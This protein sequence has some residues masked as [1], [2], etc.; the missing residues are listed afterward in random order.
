[1]NL[2]K[3]IGT[4]LAHTNTRLSALV[5]GAVSVI[6]CS[7]G[8]GALAARSSNMI[9]R[10][11]DIGFLAKAMTNILIVNAQ[12]VNGAAMSINPAALEAGLFI[13]VASLG[14][15]V[16]SKAIEMKLKQDRQESYSSGPSY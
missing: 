13:G 12:S 7:I 1:M 15:V 11:Q 10:G 6:G 4:Q 14:A 9:D 5:L 2:L 16:I 8:A 3:K